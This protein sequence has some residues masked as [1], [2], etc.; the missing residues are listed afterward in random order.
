MPILRNRA[1]RVSAA[2]VALHC[3]V[4][5]VLGG[6]VLERYL[7]PV[8]PI[9]YAAFAVSLWSLLPRLRTGALVALLVCLCCA[10]FV[11]PIYPFP[12]ENNLAFVNFVNL[13]LRA[14]R[15][16]EDQPGVLATTFPMANA[17]RRPE[18]GFV[19]Q[20]RK[21]REL[22]DFRPSTIALLRAN[23]PDAMIVYDTAWDPL[24]VLSRG[25]GAWILKAAYGYEPPMTPDA[26]AGALSMRV[27]RHWDRGGLSMSLL[28]S[29]RPSGR[30]ARNATD[31]GIRRSD[32]SEPPFIP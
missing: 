28:V 1:W 5:S 9:L 7:L 30:S 2:F 26:I 6:A 17:F 18:F 27:A 24:H 20:P 12:F 3:V 29:G 10:N 31:A 8:L 15:A 13:E 16:A 23:P 25:P 32:F 4:V 22:P 14:A 11:N 21:V 19:L